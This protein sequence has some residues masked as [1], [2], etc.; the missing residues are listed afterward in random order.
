MQ[1]TERSQR[2]DE[3]GIMIPRLLSVEEVGEILGISPETV[4]ELVDEFRLGYVRLSATK[5]AYTMELLAEF[6]EGETVHR[7]W[8]T[9]AVRAAWEAEQDYRVE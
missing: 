4:N 9:C 5:R 1:K 8:G 2:Q 7:D 6:I 3:Q